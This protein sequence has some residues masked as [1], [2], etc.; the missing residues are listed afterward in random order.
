MK[1]QRLSMAELENLQDDFVKFLASQGIDAPMWQALKTKEIAKAEGIID[2]YSD[3]V[4]AQALANCDYLE[5]IS[6]KE[7]KSIRFTA[8][9][10]VV[11]GVKVKDSSTINLN[12]ENFNEV[13]A[14]G[15]DQG[16]VTAF[17]GAKSFTEER[18]VE[19]FSWIK[20]GAYMAN[21]DWYK[22]LLQ[23]L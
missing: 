12:A 15:I 19:M 16:A 23:L 14:T 22:A 13:L 9:Q 2:V 20:K 8:T 4:Y 1:F 17:T 7:F 18:A 21:G 5:H 11:V 6:A 10:A 3:L